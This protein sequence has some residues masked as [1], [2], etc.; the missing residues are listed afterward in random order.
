[1]RINVETKANPRTRITNSI[2]DKLLPLLDLI[3]Y[4]LEVAKEI[5]EVQQPRLLSRFKISDMALVDEQADKVKSNY[6]KE[7]DEY[8]LAT[9]RSKVIND[10]LVSSVIQD[11]RLYNIMGEKYS[12]QEL[13]NLSIESLLPRVGYIVADENMSKIT[14]MINKLDDR[15]DMYEIDFSDIIDDFFIGVKNGK[16]SDTYMMVKN[17]LGKDTNAAVSERILSY[18]ESEIL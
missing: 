7:E 5:S 16:Y 11:I 17:Y 9:N 3:N 13:I 18:I 15:K 1:M 2:D 6:T 12:V 10:L 8:F 14:E 4:G